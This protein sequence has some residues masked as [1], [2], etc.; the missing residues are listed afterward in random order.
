MMKKYSLA[1]LAF[2]FLVGCEST[3]YADLHKCWTQ[4]EVGGDKEV[5]LVCDDPSLGPS[6]FRQSYSFT[7][8]GRCDYL[9]LAPNDAHYVEE[10]SYKLKNDNSLL[11]IKDKNGELLV[12]FVIRSLSEDRLVLKRQ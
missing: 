3:D 8:D 12:S 2:L 11:E 7:K 9:V 1:L 4:N 6:W 5:Y 10:G